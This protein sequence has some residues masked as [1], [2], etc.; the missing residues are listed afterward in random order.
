MPP[1]RKQKATRRKPQPPAAK[2]KAPK[3]SRRRK[4]NG[5]KGSGSYGIGAYLHQLGQQIPKGTFETMGGMAGSALGRGVAQMTG[6]GNYVMNNIVS[7]DNIPKKSMS[8]ARRISHC[9]YVRDIVAPSAPTTFTV[10]ELFL[11][12]SE[13]LTFPWLSNFAK[14]FTKYRFTQ[15]LFEFRSSFSDY[16][17]GGALGSIIMT[18]QYN[19]DQPTFAN[20]QQMEA[21]DHCVSTKPSNSIWCGFECDRKENNFTWYNVRTPTTNTSPFTDPGS[22]FYATVGL[23]CA[24]NTVIGELFVHYTV[25][26]IEPILTTLSTGSLSAGKSAYANDGTSA[27]GTNATN[28]LGILPSKWRSNIPSVPIS[29]SLVVV[30]SNIKPEIVNWDVAVPSS[31]DSTSWYFRNPGQYFISSCMVFSTAPTAGTLTTSWTPSFTSGVGTIQDLEIKT[32]ADY[33]LS[34]QEWVITVLSAGGELKWTHNSSWTD[35]SSVIV[36]NAVEIIRLN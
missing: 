15:L 5:I 1:Q 11:N 35:T 23:P 14:L 2:A 7:V 13:N 30:N 10:S 25:E 8:N 28:V 29:N 16:A 36:A 4:G 12:P 26:L 17:T 3:A 20:K 24:A 9:E 33:K 19:V 32:S 34:A 18:P 6:V 27:A 31:T 22:L 21:S